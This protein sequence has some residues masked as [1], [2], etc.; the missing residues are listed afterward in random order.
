VLLDENLPV[1]VTDPVI[2]AARRV[3]PTVILRLGS[4]ESAKTLT[5]V[6]RLA[7]KVVHAGATRSSAVLAAGGGLIGNVAGL[8]ALLLFR[9]IKLIHLPTTV[10]AASD[11][12]LSLKQAVNVSG[13]KNMLGGFHAP[14]LVW[15]D[16]GALRHL[17]RSQLSAALCEG[18]KNVL[19]ITPTRIGDL[20]LIADRL[21]GSDGAHDDAM[22]DFIS[23]CIEAKTA[24]M[25]H[26]QHE[27][28]TALVLEYGHTTG[29]AIELASG[30]RV[31]HGHG[32]GV[33]ILVAA[34]VSRILGHMDA[35]VV[36]V[37]H[38]LLNRVGLRS[39]A[40]GTALKKFATTEAILAR[41]VGDNKRGYLPTTQPNNVPMVLLKTLGVPV[42]TGLLP[43][44]LVPA[45]VLRS[46][47]E[48]ILALCS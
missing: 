16:L 26:D 5:A 40:I 46:G 18:A 1:A 30:G 25:R 20:G 8:L 37:H 7:G 44:T 23:Y 41:A 21:L 10:L 28:G 13:I 4:Q 2:A 35:D 48:R 42:T 9:G 32:I 38:A 27:R 36:E 17:P 39:D 31:S 33:G 19:A 15:V 11:S 43:L 34:E 24:V 6:N 47:I 12:V 3:A 22:V 29:H 14:V 45:H